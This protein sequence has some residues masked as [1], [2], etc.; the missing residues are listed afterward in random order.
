MKPWLNIHAL[1]STSPVVLTFR[2]LDINLF[3]NLKHSEKISLK[4]IPINEGQFMIL[5]FEFIV[6]HDL[7]VVIQKGIFLFEMWKKVI[8]KKVTNQHN[9][10][11]WHSCTHSI[12]DPNIASRM[13]LLWWFNPVATL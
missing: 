10:N 8:I 9:L 5:N 7:L 6:L 4:N 12:L 3:C 2:A 11:S 13:L 1:D